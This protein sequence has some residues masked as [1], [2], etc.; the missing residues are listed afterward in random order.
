MKYSH[1][2]R[3]FSELRDD[4]GRRAIAR[5]I[6]SEL[7]ADA[8]PAVIGVFGSWGSGKSH[9]LSQAISEAFAS[10]ADSSRKLIVCTF[11]AWRYEVEGDLALG[12]VRSLQNIDDQAKN[13]NPTF[14]A[15]EFK[16]IAGGLIDSISLLA[17]ATLPAGKLV[18]TVAK[19]AGRSLEVYSDVTDDQERREQTPQVERIQSQMGQLVDSIIMSAIASDPSDDFRLVVFIDDLDRCSPESMVRM[20]EWLKVHLSVGKCSYVMALDNIAAARAIVG[21]YREYLGTDRDLGYGLRYLE[22]LFESEYELGSSPTMELM[23]L[24]KVYGRDCDHTS[25]EELVKSADAAGTDFPGIGSIDELV[26][27]RSI[28]TPRTMMKIVAKFR[29]V[30]ELVNSQHAEDFRTTLPASYP[31]WILFIIAIYFRLE[32]RHLDD[33]VRGR[34]SIYELWVDPAQV[35]PELWGGGPFRE[36][37]VFSH[38]LATRSAQAMKIPDTRI[39]MRLARVVRE[40]SLG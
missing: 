6:V 5:E 3:D 37:C 20:F 26:G 32:P 2:I 36:F 35:N 16:I 39:L 1:D 24:R 4:L 17:E 28:H 21:R 29:R 8:P 12:L 13:G 25:I 14:G 11:D 23:A 22:K 10:N 38:D 18:S 7:R 15:K 33:L 34:G 19:I 31:F 27:L 30:L 9:L 40:N